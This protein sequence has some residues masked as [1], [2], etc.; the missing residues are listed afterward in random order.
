MSNKKRDNDEIL[1][2]MALVVNGKERAE[3][4]VFTQS[5]LDRLV[6][7]VLDRP[8]LVKEIKIFELEIQKQIAAGVT[9]SSGPHPYTEKIHAL[10]PE[11][12][13][14]VWNALGPRIIPLLI[15]ALEKHKK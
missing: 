3:D 2:K 15:E 5:M 13:L 7:D 6:S 1:Y 11:Y 4:H 14:G 9:G 10:L 8:D 12:D